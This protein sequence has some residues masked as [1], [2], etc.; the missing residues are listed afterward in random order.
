LG[1]RIAIYNDFHKPCNGKSCTAF[2]EDGFYL[3]IPAVVPDGDGVC[4]FGTDEG[5]ISRLEQTYSKPSGDAFIYQLCNI[6]KAVI[7]A[8]Y[9][10]V[11]DSGYFAC[12]VACNT[13]G[14][15]EGRVV[16]K[17]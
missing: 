5:Y 14:Y 10:A 7:V 12:I 9:K 8:F 1:F 3:F 11:C 6:N 16:S 13:F 15:E 4:V 17:L 2:L